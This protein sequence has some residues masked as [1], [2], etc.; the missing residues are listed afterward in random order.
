MALIFID[1]DED[2]MLVAWGKKN[3][4]SANRHMIS[5]KYLIKCY[6]IYILASNE[7]NIAFFE[8]Y[9]KINFNNLL[10]SSQVLPVCG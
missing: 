8:L 10:L 3:Y 1:E 4:Y 9:K 7:S 5:M 6:F 2:D